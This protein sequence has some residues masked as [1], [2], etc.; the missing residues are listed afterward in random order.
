M[1][2]VFVIA[3]HWL[4]EALDDSVDPRL[5]RWITVIAEAGM[6]FFF[7]LSGFLISGILIRNRLKAEETGY[8]KKQVWKNYFIR[9][10]LR[11][12]PIYYLCIGFLIFFNVLWIKN[13]S[14][15]HLTYLSNIFF[16]QQDHWGLGGHLWSLSTE[17]QFYIIWPV[18]ILFMP[19][20]HLKKIVLGIVLVAPLFRMSMNTWN[21]SFFTQL[22]TPALFDGLGLGALLALHQTL[23]TTK[24]ND[25]SP[26]LMKTAGLVG[27]AL[28]FLFEIRPFSLPIWNEFHPF[29]EFFRRSS[30]ALIGVFLVWGSVKGFKGIAKWTLENSVIL[31][32]GKISYGLY[33]FHNFQLYLFEWFKIDLPATGGFILIHF[34][35]LVAV[36]SLSWYVVELPVN[37][38]K[39]YFPYIRKTPE[40]AKV[41]PLAVTV[42]EQT[43]QN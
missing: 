2:T 35:I 34:A 30:M 40:V 29:Y 24:S 28:L 42:T 10:T 18:I 1:L 31:Y 20:R 36:A 15:W 4:P 16:Y 41:Q 33:L 32:F 11:I 8:S 21:P 38:L 17:E 14:W 9:R 13:I 5:L 23:P 39:K 22:L 12:F 7:V 26:R 6:Y 37:N 25:T 43:Y 3:A 19:L 27:L